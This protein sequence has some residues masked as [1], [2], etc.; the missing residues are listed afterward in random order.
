MQSRFI[1]SLIFTTLHG[2][3][4][5]DLFLL[6]MQMKMVLFFEAGNWEELEDRWEF[7]GSIGGLKSI[8]VEEEISLRGL[9]D[10]I[11]AKLGLSK[12]TM[13]LVLSYTTPLNKKCSP[14]C[15]EG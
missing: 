12:D 3:Y 11:Y 6:F 8:L 5:H 7:R 14:L 15:L 10:K 2:L 9:I 13:D 1:F 4:L